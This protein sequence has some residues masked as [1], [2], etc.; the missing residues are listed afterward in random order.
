MQYHFYPVYYD[1]NPLK[2]MWICT[3]H[4]VC[5]KDLGTAVVNGKTWS[6]CSIMFDCGNSMDV[7]CAIGPLI[8][9]L[10]G[11]EAPPK[12]MGTDWQHS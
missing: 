7:Y 3:H 9:G 12:Q 5:V 8:R 2:I 11:L 1:V 10:L 4:I 6:K